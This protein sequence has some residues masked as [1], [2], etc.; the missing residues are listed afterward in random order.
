V[1][2][3][4]NLDPT[5]LTYRV[6]RHW[7]YGMIV[8]RI[9]NH[10]KGRQLHGRFI[11]VWRCEYVL[12]RHIGINWHDIARSREEWKDKVGVAKYKATKGIRITFGT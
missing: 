8:T 6:L 3:L 2:R 10:N 5:R 9:G 12:H 4:E 11:Q 1:A 7:D